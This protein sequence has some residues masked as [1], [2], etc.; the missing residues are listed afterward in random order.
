MQ[1]DTQK[2]TATITLDPEKTTVKRL[3]KALEKKGF[4]SSE[5]SNI[6]K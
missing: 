2:E 3:I 4:E 1:V 6:L 5:K